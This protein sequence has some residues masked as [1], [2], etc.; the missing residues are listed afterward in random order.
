M[1]LRLFCIAWAACVLTCAAGPPPAA[2]PRTQKAPVQHSIPTNNNLHR[3]R[4]ASGSAPAAQ[5]EAEVPPPLPP[6]FLDT[7]LAYKPPPSPFRGV[8]LSHCVPGGQ[9]VVDQ[10]SK[11]AQSC[12]AKHF[13]LTHFHYDHYGGLSKHFKAGCIYCTAETARLVQVKLKVRSRELLQHREPV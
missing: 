13:I 7:W 9:F 12:G 5:P 3:S 4:A 10:F 2:V 11:A 8:P 6:S 1:T